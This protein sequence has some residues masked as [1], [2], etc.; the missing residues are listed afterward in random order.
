MEGTPVTQSLDSF[1]CRKILKVGNKSYV[2]FSLTAA[3]KNGL[4]GISR[5]P[6][7]MRVLLEN[8]LRYEDGQTSP[9]TTSRRWRIG[10]RPAPPTA[11]SPSG[12]LAC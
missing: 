8:L 9:R 4:K 10:S 3:E 12:P 2:T 6:Y 1:K 11:R 5:L 7:S